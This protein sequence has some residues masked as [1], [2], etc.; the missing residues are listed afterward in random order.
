MNIDMNSSVR[1]VSPQTRSYVIQ[2]VN[3]RALSYEIG[4][5]GTH[6]HVIRKDR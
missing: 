6:A 3:H 1:L 4:R 5:V 2:A